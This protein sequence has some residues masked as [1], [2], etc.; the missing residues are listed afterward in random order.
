[1]AVEV[2]ESMGLPATW[3]NDGVKG[4]VSARPEYTSEGLPQMSHLRVIRP[5]AGYLLAMKCMASRAPAYD[6]QDDRD[7][8]AF[9]IEHAG[10]RTADDVLA[11]VERFYPPDRILPKIHFML[12]EVFE[13]ISK[14]A[15]QPPPNI[16]HISSETPSTS[17]RAKPPSGHEQ[18]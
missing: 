2:A 12:L 18:S 5:S 7:D 3:L 1:L 6:S 11:V 13:N 15:S 9:L 14:R 16:S 10:L 4:F 17:G 8:I